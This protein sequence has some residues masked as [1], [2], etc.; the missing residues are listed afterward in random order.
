MGQILAGISEG[1]HSTFAA[2]RAATNG[3]TKKLA[4][5]VK[6]LRDIVQ[7]AIVTMQ[8]GLESDFTAKLADLST[9]LNVTHLTVRTVETSGQASIKLKAHN[10]CIAKKAEDNSTKKCTD[11]TTNVT[12]FM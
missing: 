5:R 2:T 8:S 9:L 3:G 11:A 12:N 6:A 7:S 4:G 10:W 1:N